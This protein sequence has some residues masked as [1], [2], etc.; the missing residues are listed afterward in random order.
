ME[1]EKFTQEA[2]IHL[3][4]LIIRS[5]YTITDYHSYHNADRPCILRHDVD[6]D[7]QKAVELAE[8][9]RYGIEGSPIRS[10]FFVLLSTGMYN[11][12]HKENRYA[13]KKIVEL[14]HEIG[15]HFD[16]T[17]YDIGEDS[18]IYI[19]AI[20]EELHILSLLMGAPVKVI[21]MHR[22]SKF[23]LEAN[24]NIPGIINSYNNE[25]FRQFKY[26]SDSRHHWRE[27]VENIIAG[28]EYNK[29]HI[30]THPFVYTN[31]QGD[32]RQKLLSHI[33]L[34]NINRF[35]NLDANIRE[36]SEFVKEEDI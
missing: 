16:E 33:R 27:S 24:I 10:T 2:Y 19:K 6:I 3:L 29:L 28:Q 23:T 15:L 34:G 8:L 18:S 14:G 32:F 12:F 20:E 17:V 36:L 4:E 26:F 35:H 31:E 25:F 11:V 1:I 13:L 21:S 7:I 22:P 9:E 5:G 30:V